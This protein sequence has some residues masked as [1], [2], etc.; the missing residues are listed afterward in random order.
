[1]S[2]PLHRMR[3]SKAPA[4]WPSLVYLRLINYSFEKVTGVRAII[5]SAC[6][7]R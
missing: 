5:H 6:R 7:K 4:Q 2:N 1:M 3:R